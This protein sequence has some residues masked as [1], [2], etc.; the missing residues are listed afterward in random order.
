[1]QSDPHES[2]HAWL[3]ELEKLPI[4]ECLALLRSRNLGR[5]GFE[6]EQRPMIL[7][8]NYRVIANG[9]VFRAAPGSTLS[10]ALMRARDAFEVDEAESDGRSGWSVLVVGQAT[11]LTDDASVREARALAV[12]PWAPGEHDHF[13]VVPADEIS[14]RRFVRE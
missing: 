13:I 1:M 5:V 9:V 10:A 3:G 8:V 6:Y 4:R 14:G 7:P 12:S 2:H 11:E